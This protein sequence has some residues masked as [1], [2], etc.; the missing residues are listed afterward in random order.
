MWRYSVY[1]FW[2]S[3]GAAFLV[4]AVAPD[5][6]EE[7]TPDDDDAVFLTGDSQ[8]GGKRDKHGHS[9]QFVAV[10]LFCRSPVSKLDWH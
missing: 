2:F 3:W 4:N 1:M 6:L 8:Y 5:I 7:R 10:I 9:I